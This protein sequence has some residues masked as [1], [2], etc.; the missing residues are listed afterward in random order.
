V[1]ELLQLLMDRARRVGSSRVLRRATL[2]TCWCV[3][4]ID[5]AGL[6]FTPEQWPRTL[7]W[8]G[9][10]RG[11]PAVELAQWL[12]SERAPEASLG[13]AVLNA[14]VNGPGNATLARARPIA[15]SPAP[16][17]AVF[18]HFDQQVR[19]AFVVVVGHYPGLD[20]RWHH[21]DY[22]C[23]ERRSLPGALPAHAASALLPRADW[24]FITA[25]AIANH[26]LPELLRLCR[27]ARV[28]LMGPSLPWLTD[29]R[30]FGVH[31]LAGTRVDDSNELVQVA[32]EGGGTRI[33]EHS[34]SYHVLELV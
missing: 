33:F 5:D 6:C 29:W 4:E 17:L 21:V 31:Y 22:A 23:I 11:R 18:E 10:L 2:G 25:S 9:T 28:V 14:L 7:P 16:H 15:P 8:S 27:R 3:A 1:K 12:S 24:V 32:V 20:E 34:V 26:T 19:G 30:D 13:L